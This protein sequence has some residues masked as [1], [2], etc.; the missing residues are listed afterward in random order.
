MSGFLINSEKTLPVDWWADL[1]DDPEMAAKKAH[2]AYSF[3]RG[4]DESRQREYDLFVRIYENRDHIGLR[5]GYGGATRSN[6]R[7]TLNVTKQAGDAITAKITKSQPLAR[8]Q[9]FGGNRSLMR[10]AKLLERWVQS[11]QYRSGFDRLAPDFFFD[12]VETG[13]GVMK[14]RTEGNTVCAERVY[15]GDVL[16]DAAEAEDRTPQQMYHRSM[17][18]RRV[19]MSMFPKKAAELEDLKAG[20][21]Y[22]YT[23]A[24]STL[25][26]KLELVEVWRLPSK[27]GAKDGFRMLFCE[28]LYLAHSPWAH[29]DFPFVFIR[30][31]I[32]RKGFWGIGLVEEVLGLHIDVNKTLHRIEKSLQYSHFQV[33]LEH[34]SKVKGNVLTNDIG[35]INH[36]RNTPPV[37]ATPNAVAPEQLSH[38][39]SQIQR[40]FAQAG[41]SMEE[42]IGVNQL[43]ADASGI[44]RREFYDIGT[45]RF[46]VIAEQWAW[47]YMDAAKW[48]VRLGKEIAK[49]N[50]GYKVVAYR[51]RNTVDEVDWAE[52]DM[53]A[54]TYV[55]R[56]AP[57]SSLPTLPG[58]RQQ[59]VLDLWREGLIPD[60]STALSL[61]GFPDFDAFV[62]LDQAT[63]NNIDRIIERILD[64][65]IYEDPEPYMNMQLALKRAQAAYNKALDDGVP[66]ENLEILRRFMN[67]THSLMQRAAAAT[68]PAAPGTPPAPGPTGQPPMAATPQ[69]GA[70]TTV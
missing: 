12:C 43:G 35:A 59:A 19:L 29:D 64:D 2:S 8:F 47:A 53:E 23:A 50:K 62:A 14:F 60:R 52:V 63:L 21:S 17:V 48:F 15:P 46:A 38:L 7:S 49:K 24:S 55:I 39:A 30:W 41:I 9:T 56:V 26:D 67:A 6:S 32:P 66:E 57:A 25:S 27:S 54:D 34:S 28:G 70:S 61:V 10:R 37:F 5:S 65:G 3:V 51:D 20:A 1:P 31:T 13:T 11:E 68:A 69:D 36:Y 33:W 4:N 22:D 40:V 45:Q 44:A 16:V 58:P 42:A 18:D